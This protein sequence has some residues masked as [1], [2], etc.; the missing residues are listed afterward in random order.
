MTGEATALLLAAGVASSVAV[1]LVL[2]LRSTL[3]R[4]FGAPVAYSAWFTVPLVV[5][6]TLLPAAS[7]HAGITLIGGRAFDFARDLAAALLTAAPALPAV[8]WIWLTGA[9]LAGMA[10]AVRQVRFIRSLGTIVVR[11]GI[12]YA[13]RTAVSPVVIGVL[14]PTIIVP[15]DFD[16]RYTADERALILA[17]EHTHIRRGD[18]IAN[19][20]CSLI[21][22]LLWFNPLIHLAAGRFRFDQELACDAKTLLGRSRARKAYATAILKTV[23]LDI[24]A[25]VGSPWQDASPLLRRLQ[26]LRQPAVPPRRRILGSVLVS[27]L[28][29]IA[30][31]GAWALRPLELYQSGLSTVAARWGRTVTTPDAA[32]PL[33]AKQATVGASSVQRPP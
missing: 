8:F 4:I 14:R 21:T 18:L 20:I 30:T 10:L 2:F 29:A 22:C 9:L 15:A 7:E 25:P 3:R 1:A 23:S 16:S 6:V 19:A 26:H 32:C 31:C 17:H 28:M 24:R 12:A 13:E 5:T 33:T 11:D 27:L